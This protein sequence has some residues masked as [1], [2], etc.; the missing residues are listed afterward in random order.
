MLCV[1]CLAYCLVFLVINLFVFINFKVVHW[2]H[3]GNAKNK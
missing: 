3:G 2:S 1:F